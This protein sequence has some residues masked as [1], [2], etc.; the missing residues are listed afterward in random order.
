VKGNLC[1]E[2]FYLFTKT[3][4][5]KNLFLFIVLCIISTVTWAQLEVI[6]ISTGYV[7]GTPSVY[8]SNDAAWFVTNPANLTY[9]PKVVNAH[10]GTGSSGCSR[11]ISPQASAVISVGAITSVDSGNYTYERSF[12]VCHKPTT[13][14]IEFTAIGADNTIL[15]FRVNNKPYALNLTGVDHF[16]PLTFNKVLSI[17][18]AD[19]VAGLNKISIVVRNRLSGQ[20]I[21]TTSGLNICG[22]VVT[23]GIDVGPNKTVC[24]GSC[25]TLGLPAVPNV[26]YV[27]T[28]PLG[29][30]AGNSAQITDC[31]AIAGIYTVITT[32][33]QLGCSTTG[34]VKVTLSNTNN[35]AF[36]VDSICTPG[37]ATFYIKARPT[38]TN[39]NLTPGFGEMYYIERISGPYHN[40]STSTNPS[41]SCWWVYPN[42]VYFWGYADSQNVVCSTA[43][44]KFSNY[45]CYRITRGTWNAYCPWAQHS[46]VVCGC[47]VTAET[48]R[49]I[50]HA[51]L[52]KKG[53]DLGHLKLQAQNGKSKESVFPNPSNGRFT[54]ATDPS[55][56]ARIEVYSPSGKLLQQMVTGKNTNAVVDLSGQPS[57][58][59][60]AKIITGNKVVTEK[61]VL[62]K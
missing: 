34:G 55:G 33:T 2:A 3:F 46:V 37:A 35:P 58:T 31:P 11:W 32:N 45:A 41:P 43:P 1:T 49:M 15:S 62:V 42:N 54:I 24:A 50:A 12:S 61:L 20:G 44:G 4:C 52:D 22:R 21:L 56:N 10:A 48:Q 25:V 40:T 9:R 6:D 18:T 14:R 51:H 47:N 30:P 27:W 38:V 36:T 19:I 29:N 53:P 26:Q 8:G 7:N 60:T 28:D 17:D 59:Y 16:N 39:A 5:M 13:A 57:G 23:S